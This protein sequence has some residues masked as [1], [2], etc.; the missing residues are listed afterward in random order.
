MLLRRCVAKAEK[1]QNS[2]AV[3]GDTDWLGMRDALLP[4]AWRF[5]IYNTLGDGAG[6]AAGAGGSEGGERYAGGGGA[7]PP[8]RTVLTQVALAIAALA[9]KMPN[10]EAGSI[11]SDLTGYFLADPGS[12]PAS[13]RDI[14]LQ[15]GGG[16]GGGGDAQQLSA[17]GAQA[18][19][20]AGM[21]CLLQILAVLPD[22]CTSTQLSI[23][24]NRRAAVAGVL[25]LFAAAPVRQ[26]QK[27]K[28]H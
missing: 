11:V 14:V 15:R 4:M 12:A 20:A 21:A 8:P 19:T 28:L 26:R 17:G 7:E 6:A 1:T 25:A 18:V 10:W 16:G 2:H 23:H 22:E 9:C 5:A 3:L 27:Q 24:P 13:A